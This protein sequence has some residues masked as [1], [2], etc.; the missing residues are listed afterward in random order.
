MLTALCA[1]ASWGLWGGPG[2]L[3]QRLKAF[4]QAHAPVVAAH[5][6]PGDSVLVLPQSCAS[7]TSLH[8]GAGCR[9]MGGSSRSPHSGRSPP[10]TK[11][12][13]PV[14]AGGGLAPSSCQGP[15]SCWE[16]LSF[17]ASPVDTSLG[18]RP[19]SAAW[20]NSSFL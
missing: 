16:S 3:C 4:C 14:Q 19:G 10:P 6:Q 8:H 9:W 1:E 5:F 12:S 18:A 7:S 2:G 17:K 11:S 15:P 13:G 20:G